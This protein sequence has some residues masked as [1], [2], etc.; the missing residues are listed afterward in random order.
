LPIIVYG[1]MTDHEGRPLAVDVYRGNPGDPS[2]V[3]DPVNKL[4]QRFHWSRVVR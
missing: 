2:T 3:V 4:R 1:L